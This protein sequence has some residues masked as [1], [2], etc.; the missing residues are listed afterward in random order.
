MTE[1]V[2][3]TSEADPAPAEAWDRLI[4]EVSRRL[5]PSFG[6]IDTGDLECLVASVAEAFRDARVQQYLPILIER[7]VRDA[8]RT[9][10]QA[11]V[12]SK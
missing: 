5:H 2:L 1:M 3:V 4:V 6:P 9:G 11:T 12:A 7:R 10:L 8:V